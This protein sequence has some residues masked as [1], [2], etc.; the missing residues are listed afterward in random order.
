MNKHQI[1]FAAAGSLM[2]VLFLITV[3]LITSPSYLWFIYPAFFLILWPVSV[4]LT[5][6][7]QYKL[8]AVF[9]SV[10]AVS[11]LAVINFTHSPEHPWVIYTLPPFVL[12]PVIIYSE[13]KAKTFLFA[14]TASIFT[15]LYY[16]LANYILS[17][18]HP[19]AIYP[20]F[21]VLWWP[22]AVYYTAKRDYFG[23]SIAG[24]LL[25]IVFFIIVNAVSSPQTIWAIY[26][27]F[28]ILWW[29][30]SMYYFYYKR[31]QLA[32]N[33]KISGGN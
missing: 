19:W 7:K 13:K 17:P 32:A 20:A 21:P 16:T 23:F 8:H 4:I 9:G 10:A 30:L 1:G 5:K 15:I 22:L 25:T 31:Q 33:K 3:N 29:P 27:A 18:Q 24:S 11:F 26:P 2:T 14:L 12:W 28:V 6:T